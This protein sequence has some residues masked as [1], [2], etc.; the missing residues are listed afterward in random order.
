MKVRCP[1]TR[2][3]TRTNIECGEPKFIRNRIIEPVDA[4]R[5]YIGKIYTK[6]VQETESSS[7]NL[8]DLTDHLLI[9]PKPRIRRVYGPSTVMEADPE[10][11]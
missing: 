1:R 5:S 3:C 11:W 2:Q 7:Q 4:K 8:T 10:L 9:N 6:C